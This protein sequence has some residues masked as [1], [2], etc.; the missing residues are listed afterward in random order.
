MSSTQTQP[1]PAAA[2]QRRPPGPAPASSAPGAGVVIDPMRLA[3]QYWMWL[4]GAG[5]AALFIGVV[6]FFLLRKF[7]P[8]YD[9]VTSFQVAPLIEG[10]D[11]LGLGGG[12]EEELRIYME[13]QAYSLRSDQILG[14]VARLSNFAGTRFAKEFISD[15]G[16]IDDIRALRELR[17]RVSSRRIPETQI[18]TLRVRMADREDAKIIA[19]AIAEVYLDD[20]RARDSRELRS[21]KQL[22]ERQIS[23]LRGEITSLDTRIQNLLGSSGITSINEANSVSLNEVR[24]LQP[25]LVELVSQLAQTKEQ[26][27]NYEANANN[28][29]GPIIPEG[30]R[31]RVEREPA[32]LQLDQQITNAKATLRMLKG[33]APN[34][35]TTREQEEIVKAL[36]GERDRLVVEKAD[37]MFPMMLEEMRN[38]VRNLESAELDLSQ[39]LE[40][41]RQK[42]QSTT[43]VIKQHDDLKAERDKKLEQIKELEQ[44][45]ANTDSMIDRP[46]RVREWQRSQLPDEI[47][48]PKPIPIIGAALVLIPG[49][50]GGLIV[51]KEIREQRVRGPQDVLLIPRTRLLGVVPDLA[52]DPSNPERIEGICSEHPGGVVAEAIRQLR[53]SLV[54]ECRERGHRCVLF[55]G[56]LPGAGVTATV[57]NLALSVAGTETQVLLIDANL[58]RPRLHSLLG[59]GDHPG[60]CEALRGEVAFADAV[61][62]TKVSN[63]SLMPAG[64]RDAHIYEK[65]LTSRMDELMAQAKRSYDW[66]II[67]SPPAV[68]SSDALAIA[69]HTDASVLV[70]R[71]LSEKRGLVA[72]LRNQFSECRA[73]FL[74]VVVNGVKA[75]AGGYFRR[76]FQATHEYGRDPAEEAPVVTP[77]SANGSLASLKPAPRIETDESSPT[78]N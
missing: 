4:A 58:R 66:V 11:D 8:R 70:V 20:H 17:K 39:K 49:L 67:D 76:N 73:D 61:V 43:L 69:G 44:R 30:V 12:Q 23:T 27:K 1:P 18:M 77:I 41:A 48:F 25:T 32:V 42:L 3:R 33:R 2:P 13:T 62:R 57:V 65:F 72:R 56:G 15:S 7:M 47:A 64:K 5:V 19:D 68:V 22:W 9:A 29:G 78:T 54:R 45:V 24:T 14:Q 40:T 6:A 28:P 60:L 52:L 74:G 53:T 34:G 51:L 36:E 10:A 46:S 31:M 21:Q 35:R 71:A 37:E 16:T 63:I 26:L 38:E 75:S 55:T 50:V 59:T